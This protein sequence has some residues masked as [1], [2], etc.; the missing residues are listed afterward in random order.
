MLR[1]MSV[2]QDGNEGVC[3]RFSDG[4]IAGYVV[5]ELLELRPAR[6]GDPQIRLRPGE[7]RVERKM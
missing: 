1:I 6:E 3:V 4:T 5:E 7:T 2:E